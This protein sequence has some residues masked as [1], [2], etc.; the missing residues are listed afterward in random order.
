DI[1]VPNQFVADRLGRK[2]RD[3]LHEAASNE[4]GETVNL[5]FRIDPGSFPESAPPAA[6]TVAGGAGS[7]STTVAVM[8]TTS[9]AA[10]GNGQAAVR[11]LRHRLDDFVVG[12]S[13]E[14]A[15]AA[16][17]GMADPDDAASSTLFLHGGCG[18]GKTHLLQGVC[19]RL[20][21][22]NRRA[23]VRYVTG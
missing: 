14:L 21:E 10:A 2:F 20:M 23:A 3:E 1:D 6:R 7:N 13:N 8:P 12:P 9:P 5:A 11:P 4:L 17:A 16:A 18:L 15:Y 22:R 19:N